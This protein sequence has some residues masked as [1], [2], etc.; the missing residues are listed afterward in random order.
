LTRREFTS[1]YRLIFGL[2]VK[3]QQDLMSWHKNR[4]INN[5]IALLP[6]SGSVIL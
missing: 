1:G 6:N 3:E 4:I 2:I 5:E